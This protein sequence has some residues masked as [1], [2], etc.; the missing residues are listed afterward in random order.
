MLGLIPG[1]AGWISGLVAVALFAAFWI[2]FQNKINK[3]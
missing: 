2:W 3:D 1:A